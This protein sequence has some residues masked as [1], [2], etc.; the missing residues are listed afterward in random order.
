METTN[1]I[2]LSMI[3]AGSI[4]VGE[5]WKYKNVISPFYR[6]YYIENGNGSVWINN[7]KYDLEAGDLFL[8]P[9]FAVHSYECENSMDVLYICFFDD[10][11]TGIGIPNPGLLL[12]KTK[13]SELEKTLFRR[14]IFLNPGKSLRTYDPRYYNNREIYEKHNRRPSN[15]Q[16]RD[17]ESTGI[18]L[19]LF[20]RFV[21]RECLHT[22]SDFHIRSKYEWI[23]RHIINNLDKKITIAALADMIALT[24]DHFTRQFKKVMGVS[25]NEY[26]Q[27][28]RIEYAQSIL[29][30]SDLSIVEVGE[31]VGI[32]N[33]AQFARLFAKVVH[34]SPSAYR[35]RFSNKNGLR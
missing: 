9:K 24:P 27:F 28:K 2:T 34:C 6:L 29:H 10:L 33:P 19:Q 32:P 5:W 4:R 17:M 30:A 26:I 23:V 13:A 15:I 11:I 31:A 14:Y 3:F 21:T 7:D 18:L 22:S 8:T 1:S 35:R 25:P 20:A 12:L 16:V